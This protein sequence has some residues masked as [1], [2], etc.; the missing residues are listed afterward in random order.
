MTVENINWADG[1]AV[2]HYR[3]QRLEVFY[4]NNTRVFHYHKTDGDGVAVAYSMYL[5]SLPLAEA[6]YILARL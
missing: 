2:L 1:H 3:G 6:R 4:F 5:A